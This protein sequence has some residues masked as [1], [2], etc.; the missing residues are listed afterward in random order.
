MKFPL[1]YS[2]KTMANKTMANKTGATA[3]TNSMQFAKRSTTLMKDI[4]RNNVHTPY[5]N[6]SSQNESGSHYA[7]ERV[8]SA[9]YPL[10]ETVSNMIHSF[11]ALIQCR[12]TLFKY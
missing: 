3:I 10:F 6:N 1:S 5:L 12:K 4:E 9:K 11:H 7:L 2:F 8:G